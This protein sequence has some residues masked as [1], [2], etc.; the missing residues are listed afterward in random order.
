MRRPVE[1]VAAEDL[2]DVGDGVLGQQHAAEHA[3]A[4]PRCPA[5]ACGPN[6][7]VGRRRPSATLTKHTPPSTRPDGPASAVSINSTDRRTVTLSQD[8]A[9]ATSP[10]ARAAEIGLVDNACGRTPRKMGIPGLRIVLLLW[11]SLWTTR[12]ANPCSGPSRAPFLSTPCGPEKVSDGVYDVDLCG[13]H[14]DRKMLGPPTPRSCGSPSPPSAPSS[15]SHCSCWPTAPS[16]GTWAPRSWPASAWRA[17]SCRPGLSLRLPGVRQHRRRG[18][19]GRRRRP[20]RGHRPGCRRGLAGPRSRLPARRGA[21][22]GRRAAR[23]RVRHVRRCDAVRPDLP[24]GVGPRPAGDALRPRRHG[25]AARPAGHGHPARSRHSRRRREHRPEPRARLPAGLGIAGSALGTVLAQTGMAAAF[26]TVVVRGARREHASLR[27]DLPG[28][29]AAG[30]AGVPLMVRTL[31]LRAALLF[32]PPTSPRPRA[33]WP[34]RPTR[35]PS[36]SGYSCR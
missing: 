17:P 34:S 21:G 28:I 1:V 19:P 8:G 25:S 23:G 32:S 16:S 24:A 26:L 5:A 22:G 12:P 14:L 15:P 29:R 3:T 7:A 33:R 20:A 9:I 13:R 4:R 31:T 35:S 2:D 27:P 11:T 36:P 6:L 18:A 30:R 10:G